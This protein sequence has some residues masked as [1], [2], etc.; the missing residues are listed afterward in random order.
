MQNIIVHTHT[1]L[2]SSLYTNIHLST[3]DQAPP[4]CSLLYLVKSYC[5]YYVAA[6]FML[7]FFGFYNLQGF[8]LKAVVGFFFPLNHIL[9]MIFK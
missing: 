5:K 6:P 9:N 8:T 7:V 3:Q 2:W 4:P 1:H